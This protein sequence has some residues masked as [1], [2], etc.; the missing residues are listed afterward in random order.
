MHLELL[1]I[2]AELAEREKGRPNYVSLRRSVSTAYYALFHAVADLCAKQLV[3][4]YRHCRHSTT[5]TDR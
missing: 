5:F 1:K 2:A 4:H 3:G